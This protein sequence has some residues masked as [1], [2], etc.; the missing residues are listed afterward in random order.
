MKKQIEC[1]PRTI[2]RRISLSSYASP[3]VSPEAVDGFQVA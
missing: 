2:S 3:T 1:R